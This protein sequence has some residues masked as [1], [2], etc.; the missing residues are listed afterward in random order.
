MFYDRFKLLADNRGISVHKATQDIGLSN[1]AATKWKN[2]G[3]TPDSSTLMKISTYFE[4]TIDEL[5]DNEI[6]KDAPEGAPVKSI[7]REL[8]EDFSV[9]SP[10]G[11]KNARDYLR[12]LKQQENKS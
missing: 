10:E 5:L 9:L 6:K 12:F 11:Q 2:K 3:A 4:I 8:A 7:E 1:S